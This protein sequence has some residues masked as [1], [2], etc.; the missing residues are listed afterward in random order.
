MKKYL[1]GISYH[2]PESYDSWKKGI[3]EDYESSTGIFIVA[4]S[5]NEAISWAEEIGEKLFQKENPNELSSWKSFEYD[6][7][8]EHDW[9]KSGWSHCLDFFQT[10]NYGELPDLNKMGTKAYIEWIENKKFK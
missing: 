10:I 4:N 2:E 5:K 9:E 3:I 7:W 6:C 8:I 1:V